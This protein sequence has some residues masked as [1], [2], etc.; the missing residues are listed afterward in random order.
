[1]RISCD[2]K[3]CKFNN[4]LRRQQRAGMDGEDFNDENMGDDEHM[5]QREKYRGGCVMIVGAGSPVKTINI[6]KLVEMAI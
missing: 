2:L 6:P 1:M 3:T 5:W 4:G